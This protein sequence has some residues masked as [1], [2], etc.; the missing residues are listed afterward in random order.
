[1]GEFL[2]HPPDAAFYM[3][4]AICLTVILGRIIVKFTDR[5]E[6]TLERLETTC[7]KLTTITEVQQVQILH[8]EK[9]IDD[10]ED[11]DKIVKYSK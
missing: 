4:L 9:R 6:A 11:K 7:A 1:M 3:L 5:V 8:H 2:A 10:L